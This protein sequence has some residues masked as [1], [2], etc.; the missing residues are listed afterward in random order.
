MDFLLNSAFSVAEH[1][2]IK[3]E[4]EEEVRHVKIPCVSTCLTT[5]VCIRDLDKRLFYWLARLSDTLCIRDL[6]MLWFHLVV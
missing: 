3:R 6:D 5:T 4:A 2:I 1:S